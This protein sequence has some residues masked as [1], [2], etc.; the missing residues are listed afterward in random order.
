MKS[1]V[2][3]FGSYVVDL[4]ARAPHLPVPAETVRGSM[5]RMGP[6]GK[7][8]NQCV[9]A[10]K[11]GADVVMVAKVK[12]DTFGEIA[13]KTMDELG[14]PRD[15][16]LIT[17][18]TD[19]GTAVILVDEETGQNEIIITPAANDTITPEEVDGLEAR[20]AESE[21]VLLQLE[22]NQDANERMADLAS[23]HGCKIIVNTAPYNPVSDAF[24]S[25]AYMVTPNEVEAEALSGI[26]VTDEA[27]AK[28]AARYFHD[29]GVDVV[30]ITMGKLGVFISDGNR[31]ELV[32]AFQVKAIDTTGAGDAFNGGLLAALSEGKDLWEGARFAQA[33]AAL[34]VQKIGT[35]PSMPTREEIDAF[36]AEQEKG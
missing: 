24:L 21:Y 22:V 26:P 34:S 13:L 6:G 5:F 10:H 1:K 23:R 20:I 9:A 4:M 2:T 28:Q 33:L 14:M 27:S 7:G 30:V 32:P 11:A 19:T 15:Y 12:E 16:M 18:D 31:E 17:E 8:F 29:K 25:K 35:T 36:L 3:V